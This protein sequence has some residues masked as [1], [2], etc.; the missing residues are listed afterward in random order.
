MARHARQTEELTEWRLLELLLL[1]LGGGG[2][3][4][5]GCPAGDD[6]GAGAGVVRRAGSAG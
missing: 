4:G 2:G 1:L 5:G 6:A 3:G